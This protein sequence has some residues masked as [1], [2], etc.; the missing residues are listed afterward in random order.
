MRTVAAAVGAAWL[1]VG[2]DVGNAEAHARAEPELLSVLLRGLLDPPMRDRGD[3]GADVGVWGA[4]GV[5][6]T[7]ELLH[8]HVRCGGDLCQD[9]G[10]GGPFAAKSEET[11]A[12]VCSGN[13]GD[14][15]LRYCARGQG[16]RSNRGVGGFSLRLS[17]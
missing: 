13:G 16:D 9:C 15:G 11:G 14:I 4:L 1:A 12:A 17:E 10:L 7:D 6:V 8:G 2:V 5:V 3:G